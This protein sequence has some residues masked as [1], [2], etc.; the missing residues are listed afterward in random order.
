LVAA[1]SPFLQNNDRIRLIRTSRYFHNLFT[2]HIWLNLNLTPS[3]TVARFFKSP[4]GMQALRRY[5]SSVQALETSSSFFTPYMHAVL[6]FARSSTT[7]DSSTPDAARQ[8]E[9]LSLTS[10]ST[11]NLGPKIAPPKWLLQHQNNPSQT[12]NSN[13][14]N[15][16]IP[17]LPPMTNLT[18]FHGNFT[19]LDLNG[20]IIQSL[21][22]CWLLRLN[23]CLTNVRLVD[24]FLNNAHFAR[25]FPRTLSGLTRLS[26][27]YIN[28]SPSTSVQTILS[29]FANC[30]TSLE[31]L[32]MFCSIDYTITPESYNAFLDDDKRED[33]DDND[34]DGFPVAPRNGPLPKLKTLAMPTYRGGF[35]TS[36]IEIFLKDCPAL[37][38]WVMS[39]LDSAKVSREVGN[40]LRIH[41]PKLCQLSVQDASR[42]LRQPQD[43]VQI[44]NSMPAGQLETLAVMRFSETA[45][46]GL[47]E[48][49]EPHHQSGFRKVILFNTLKVSSQ[50]LQSLLR[51]SAGLQ[52][53]FVM[54]TDDRSVALNLTDAAAFPWTCLSLTHLCL[55]MDLSGTGADKKYARAV[56]VN[57]SGAALSPFEWTAKEQECWKELEVVYTT[58]GSLVHLDVLAIRHVDMSSREYS[59]NSLPGLLT[60]GNQEMNQPGFLTK[61]EGL[62]KLKVLRGSVSAFTDE[63]KVMLRQQEVEWMMAS[64]PK[65]ELIDF[66]G[67]NGHRV[68]LPG[69]LQWLQQAKSSLKFH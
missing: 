36:L 25:V 12:C 24:V 61:L 48:A 8:L 22:I 31:V 11:T 54:G 2:P 9:Q 17:P 37:E 44:I 1:L 20:N 27:L 14:N 68:V 38:M 13:N 41:C 28:S 56:S 45:P 58:L 29:I 63:S 4:E 33:E 18:K 50:T 55:T 15:N 62:K 65:V 67:V 16:N 51:Y 42:Y 10:D 35:P 7:T 40:L 5:I 60:L 23:P 6:A 34:G 57:N 43:F 30:P 69:P 53:L 59:S 64:W 47:W 52:R 21:Q 3:V 46:G 19:H 39:P 32:S 66:L 49:I 26:H